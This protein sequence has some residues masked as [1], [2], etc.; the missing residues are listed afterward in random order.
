MPHAPTAQTP[1]TPPLGVAGHFGELLQGRLGPDGPIALISLPC[2]A[3]WVD[4]DPRTGFDV[5]LSAARLA[6]L[7]A[8]L[9]L[10]VPDTAVRLRAT[11]PVG[12]GAGSSTASLVATARALGFAGRSEALA[13][14]CAR[15]EGASD[16]LMFD[17]AERLL[18]APRT[19]QILL[20]TPVLPRFTVLGGFFGP[21]SRTDPFDT[22]FPDI[23]DLVARWRAPLTLPQMAALA[24]CSARRTL[25]MRGPARDPTAGLAGDLGALGWVIAH[26]GSARGLI[27]APDAV[28]DLAAQTLCD[29]G[30]TQVLQFD[31]GGLA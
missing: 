28:P 11:M 15:V 7:C 14:I 20:Q 21:P 29:A 6:R 18:F 31:A 3:V 22:A 12:G 8:A 17:H 23:S 13:Q 1:T 24:T 30:F 19:G 4:T 26:T 2:P 10:P 25:E 27:F 9:D 16:P 5:T